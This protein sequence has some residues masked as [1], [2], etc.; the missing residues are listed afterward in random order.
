MKL[1]NAFERVFE[2]HKKRVN[3]LLHYTNEGH[4]RIYIHLDDVKRL[5]AIEKLLLYRQGLSALAD[6]MVNNQKLQKTEFIIG[7]SDIVQGATPVLERFGFSV[8]N[9]GSA[10]ANIAEMEKRGILG[11]EPIMLRDHDAVSV[12][13]KEKFI[14]KP[15]ER[16]N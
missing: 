12:M 4:E 7:I 15:W 5:N 14:T 16:S 11:I 10:D 13:S 9:N 1:K 3:E 6:R 8:F 2:P